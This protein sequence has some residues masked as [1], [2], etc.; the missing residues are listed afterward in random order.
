M[1]PGN[2]LGK[3]SAYGN[4]ALDRLLIPLEERKNPNHKEQ[5]FQLSLSLHSCNFHYGLFYCET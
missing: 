2:A 4:I 5:P 1:I 3:N